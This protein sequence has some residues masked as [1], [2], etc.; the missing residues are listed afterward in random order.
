MAQAPDLKPVS[1]LNLSCD[2]TVGEQIGGGGFGRVFAGTSAEGRAAAIK[3]V[4]KA[5][6]AERELL[7]VDLAN[8]RNVVPIL[9]SGDH[10]DW[11]VLVMP[12]AE[13]SLR[14]RMDDGSMTVDEAV[15]VLADITTALES[16]DGAVVHRDIK[17]ENVL[18]YQGVWCLAD[19]GISRYAEATTAPDT[20]KFAMS[21]P[22]AAPE[23]WR[24]ERATVAADVYA[25]GVVAFELL[26]GYRPFPGPGMEDLRDQHL[27]ANPPDLPGVSAPLAAVVAECLYKAPEA[28]PTPANL[29]ARLSNCAAPPVSEGLARLAQ[30]NHTAV[31]R[32]AE[33]TRRASNA[34]SEQERHEALHA[35]AE[36]SYDAISTSLRDALAS[37]APAAALTTSPR[38][39]WEL[40]LNDANLKFASLSAH[41]QHSWGD[42]PGPSFDV[43]GV[44]SINLRIP[45]DRFAYE[46]R[47]HSLWFGDIEAEGQYAWF[48]TAFMC[49]PLMGQRGRQDPFSFSPSDEA[50]RALGTGIA[51]FQVAWPFTR[52]AT[53][54]LTEFIDR[55]ASWFGQA[56]QGTLNHPGSMPERRPEGSWRR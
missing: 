2:W 20:H 31:E 10:G 32:S 19:F 33:A 29:Q 35:A 53:D 17:P 55:W 11:W 56:A 46:G 13:F 22:Y 14:Q 12:R 5:P 26:A 16:F 37:A 47:S 3:F 24:A 51:D 54:D 15:A 45:A 40:R 8:V 6:G 25:T 39:G 9:D 23:R 42:R 50:A 30:A 34:R 52:L 4:P 38:S 44:G 7:F 18:L 36:S 41:Y 1:V 49:Q 43:I 48:E 21:P 27:H 28:R